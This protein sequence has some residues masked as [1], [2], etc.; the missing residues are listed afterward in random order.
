MARDVRTEELR[1]HLHVQ[2]SAAAAV[3]DGGEA[4]KK[5]DEA[6]AK[7]SSKGAPAPKQGSEIVPSG[8]QL[9]PA[10]ISEIAAAM[11]ATQRLRE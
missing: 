2:V 4:F 1:E 7:A 5:M 11:A 9:T 3:S 10:Q 6:L 8:Q